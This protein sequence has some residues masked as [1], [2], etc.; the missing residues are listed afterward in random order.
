MAVFSVAQADVRLIN[1]STRAPIQ[2]GAGDIIAGFV[3]EGTG[4]QRVV[5]RG[6]DLESGVDPKL[7]LQKFPSGDFVASNDN[8]KTD[9]RYR[10]IPGDM[11]TS[12]NDID[13]ALLLDLPAGAYTVTLSS[14]GAKGIGLVGVDKLASTDADSNPP[15][16]YGNGAIDDNPPNDS[17]RLQEVITQGSHTL[18]QLGNPIELSNSS[19]T[20]T[21]D[22]TSI[23]RKEEEV[24]QCVIE[25][26]ASLYFRV[27]NGKITIESLLD[28]YTT[29]QV[30]LRDDNTVHIS[31]EKINHQ[32]DGIV[33]G[34]RM[35]G[36]Y[37]QISSAYLSNTYYGNSC[38]AKFIAPLIW[39]SEDDGI[40]P[41]PTN[42]QVTYHGEYFE[43]NWHVENSAKIK[44]YIIYR[45]INYSS[46]YEKVA[47]TTN[48]FYADYSIKSLNLDKFDTLSYYV[49]AIG[50]N[51][52]EGSESNIEYFDLF[53]EY[54]SAK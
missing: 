36:S 38:G 20:R 25:H 4:T 52:K 8:W 23:D 31:Y 44:E 33:E 3:I 46:S 54:Y 34:N 15:P 37:Y 12:F 13:A 53:W 40:P 5:I 22:T 11:T 2:G 48:T 6:W 41:A 21:I 30:S 26:L 29:A 32:F 27:N 16:S 35:S 45:S 24:Q 1:I 17:N 43:L 9:P 10:E 14:V 47:R 51:N 50:N 49:T 42:L 19:G 7:T 28:P 18:F 39:L